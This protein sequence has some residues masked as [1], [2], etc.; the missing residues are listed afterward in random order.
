MLFHKIRSLS[1]SSAVTRSQ[2]WLSFLVFV[3]LQ[4]G[5][6][7]DPGPNY[8]CAMW[9][10][11]CGGSSG[12]FGLGLGLLGGCS[13]LSESALVF[14]NKVIII[15]W[16]ALTDTGSLGHPVLCHVF[17]SFKVY[18]A[19]FYVCLNVVHIP[20]LLASMHVS[21]QQVES[22]GLVL[23]GESRECG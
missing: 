18:A 23:G 11:E 10:G 15:Q 21:L 1:S 4:M 3:G 7:A 6:E 2:V 17:P 20:F 5:V 14:W 22:K 9:A 16:S 12:G 8:F 19:L 13:L